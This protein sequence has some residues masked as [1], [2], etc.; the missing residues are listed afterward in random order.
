MIKKSAV[1]PVGAP[2]R[3]QRGFTTIELAIGLI[4]L[5]MAA[6]VLVFAAQLLVLQ[7]RCVDSATEIARQEAR[8]DVRRVAA[9]EANLPPGATVHRERHGDLAQVSVELSA[10]PWSAMPAVPLS[11]RATRALEPGEK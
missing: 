3:A 7:L 4:S 9:A 10:R 8:G 2:R 11:A 1:H 5:T 6:G